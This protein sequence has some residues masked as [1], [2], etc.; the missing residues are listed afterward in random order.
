[1]STRIE[2]DF[3][4][5]SAVHFND[6]FLINSFKT[7][8]SIIVETE[9]IREQNVAMDRIDYFFHEI[10][11]N[12]LFIDENLT[13]NIKVYKNA[14]IKII[15]LPEEPYDQIIGMVL[16]LKLNSIMEGKMHITDLNI[17]SY[18]SDWV[19]FT[20]VSEIAEHLFEDNQ[21]FHN[22]TLETENNT[23]NESKV[24]K[25]FEDCWSELGLSWKDKPKKGKIKSW[26]IEKIMYTR[27]MYT[28]NYGQIILNENDVC[29]IFYRNPNA[30]P[31][32]VITE[33]EIK[34]NIDLEYF[35]KLLVYNPDFDYDK[36]YQQDYFIP[37]EYVG[38]DI[39]KF[40]LDSCKNDGELQRAGE[41]LLLFQKNNM[42]DLLVYLKYFVDTLRSKN[43]VW[44][45]GRGSSV[46]SFVLYLIGVH[47]INS[48]Y[49]DIPITEFFKT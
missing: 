34:N 16:L 3:V 43:I 25:L 21:W 7:T 14:G 13:E 44:G 6:K 4:F 28:D 32:Y 37:K 42:L 12:S 39:A 41:E 48:L 20:I 5:H 33:S 45:V 9:D 23:Q 1:M 19:R 31:K 10:L 8:L 26:H 11:N 27:V 35:P 30:K 47:K 40:V 38:F 24:V 49:Y 18:L 36:L 46:A 2:K 15:S 29:E 17:G 22:N